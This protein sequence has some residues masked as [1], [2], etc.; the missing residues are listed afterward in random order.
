MSKL[1]QLGLLGGCFALVWA[2]PN[3]KEWILALLLVPILLLVAFIVNDWETSPK[4][5]VKSA[6][7][8]FAILPIAVG[9]KLLFLSPFI[10][11]LGIAFLIYGKESLGTR[12]LIG[13]GLI[14][15][16]GLGRTVYEKWKK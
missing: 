8:I 10:I 12:M 2:F 1:I 7:W 11:G 14:F 13:W 4:D 6:G 9:V 15:L 16:Y 3:E 5:M